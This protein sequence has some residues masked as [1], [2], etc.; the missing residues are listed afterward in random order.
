VGIQTTRIGAYPKPDYINIDNWN[1]S[2][3]AVTGDPEPREFT[4][5]SREVEQIGG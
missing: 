1:E 4:Y 3:Q 5:V 2:E